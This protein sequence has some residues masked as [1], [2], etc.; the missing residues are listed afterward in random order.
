MSTAHIYGDPPEAVCNEESPT[1]YGL[2][3]FVGKAWEEA[4]HAGA[5][6]SQRKVIMRT[7]FVIGRD[8]GAGGGALSRLRFL[9]RLGLAGRLGT[10]RQ[11]MSWIHE[12]DMN[13]LFE[14]AIG[15]DTMQGMY[16]ATAPNPVPQHEFMRTLR[17][18]IR[19]PIGLPAFS[20]MV[21]LGAPLLL[22]TDPELA[23]YGRYVVSRRLADEGFV[24]RFPELRG[25]LADLL[26]PERPY[27]LQP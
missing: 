2:A 17:Q 20:W 10:G 7:S 11:G 9:A 25:A 22:R 23:L 13:R 18:A 3:P 8:R 14:R 26:A 6:A 16:I 27:P 15:D 12:H 4:F 5:L 21:R 24:W 1:G 19:V